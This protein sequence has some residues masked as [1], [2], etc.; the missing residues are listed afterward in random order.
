MLETQLSYHV[1]AA[2]RDRE[3]GQRVWQRGSP[4]GEGTGERVERGQWKWEEREIRKCTGSGCLLLKKHKRESV[5]D[6]TWLEREK[7]WLAH[8]RRK[9]R[10][11]GT[12]SALQCY[13][14]TW[15]KYMG[16]GAFYRPRQ[17][18]L[19]LSRR[20]SRL[21]KMLYCW[22]KIPEHLL[23]PQKHWQKYYMTRAPQQAWQAS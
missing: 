6:P 18:M 3:H 9:E 21:E 11:L 5:A 13:N 2:V 22:Y 1:K 7:C 8:V 19:D 23:W 10:M 14:W 12:S 15:K 16:W 4:T 20:I 17:Q